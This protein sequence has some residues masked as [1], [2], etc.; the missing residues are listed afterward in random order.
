MISLSGPE[1][2]RTIFEKILLSQLKKC[3]EKVLLVRGLPSEA[4]KLQVQIESIKIINHLSAHELSI[5][6][7]QCDTIISRSGYSTIMDLARLG[8]NAILVPTPGQT[9]QEYL[10][11]YL[12]ERKYFY[13][14]P[15]NKFSLEDAVSQASSFPF[16]TPM[17]ANDNYKN[18]IREFVG[19]LK[20]NS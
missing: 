10:S 11:S 12:M 20:S 15:Q 4:K 14:V 9:E 3:K 5:A 8:K 2:Q 7:Q 19:H 13:A 6:F 17:P 18:I 1:P 16:I